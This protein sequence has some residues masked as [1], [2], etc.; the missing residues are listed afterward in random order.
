MTQGT[1][2]TA[3]RIY[4]RA[5][6]QFAR[7][8]FVANGVG[9]LTV[10]Y[11]TAA[12]E[13]HDPFVD[14]EAGRLGLVVHDHIV[15]SAFTPQDEDEVDA[16]VGE[17]LVPA[18]PARPWLPPFFY[19]PYRPVRYVSAQAASAAPGVSTSAWRRSAGRGHPLRLHADPA[20][21]LANRRSSSRSSPCSSL[22][23]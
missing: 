21:H 8:L 14:Y 10:P 13:R 18:A 23:R 4:Y 19:L 20:L 17:A 5:L 2:L 16:I 3:A 12:A 22:S 9:D 6:V 11:C 15:Q 7:V 1:M